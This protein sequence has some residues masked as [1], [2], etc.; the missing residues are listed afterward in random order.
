PT[1][2]RPTSTA[3]SAMP[4]RRLTTRRYRGTGCRAIR[5]T[6][7]GRAGPSFRRP[8]S[9]RSFPGSSSFFFPSR[10]SCWSTRRNGPSTRPRDRPV[11]IHVLDGVAILSGVLALYVWAVGPTVIKLFGRELLRASEPTRAQVVFFFAAGI[12][13]WLRWPRVFSFFR[14]R[15]LRESLARGQ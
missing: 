1:A 13:C 11:L 15:S 2:A 14:E 8:T 4:R 7:S 3:S 5:T 6:G 10:G 12:R 9:A